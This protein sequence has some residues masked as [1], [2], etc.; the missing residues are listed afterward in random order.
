MKKSVHAIYEMKPQIV[1]RT[2]SPVGRSDDELYRRRRRFCDFRVT[3]TADLNR[4]SFWW[5]N[6]SLNVEILPLSDTVYVA[7]TPHVG[8]MFEASE[9]DSGPR[10]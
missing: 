8:G 5:R 7:H 4:G 2:V 6:Q 10:N 9:P 1:S 3:Q